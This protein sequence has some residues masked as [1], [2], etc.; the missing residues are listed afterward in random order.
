MSLC[1]TFGDPGESDAKVTQKWLEGDFFGRF[2]HFRVTF[3]WLLRRF[4]WDWA[5]GGLLQNRNTGNPE[6]SWGGCCEECWG[7]SGCWTE[8]WQG[9]CEGGFSLERNEEQ[10]PRQHSEF[11]QHSSQ[12]PPQLFFWGSPC[13]YSVAGRPVPNTGTLKVTSAHSTFQKKGTPPLQ[14]RALCFEPRIWADWRQA[15]DTY[16]QTLVQQVTTLEDHLAACYPSHNYDTH[17]LFAVR[18]IPQRAN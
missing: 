18:I 11:P 6:N 5:P 4:Y 1:T 17:F 16:L 7:N 3:E 10:H 15:L 8:C 9:C 12:H 14:L 13:F 2:R